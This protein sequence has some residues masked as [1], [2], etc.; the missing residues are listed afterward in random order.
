MTVR[1]HIE[2]LVLDGMPMTAGES[3][4]VQAAVQHELARLVTLDG[5]RPETRTGAV[6]PT[7]KG[8]AFNPPRGAGAKEL[9]RHIAQSVHG[10]IGGTK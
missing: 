3:R 9:G 4:R 6:M 10:G 1:I 2:R 7:A 5:L 8:S